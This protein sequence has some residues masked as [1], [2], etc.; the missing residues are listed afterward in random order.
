MAAQ[1]LEQTQQNKGGRPS[2][3]A[4]V[5]IQRTLRP[6][7]GRGMTAAYTARMTGINIKTVCK[8]FDEWANE[9]IERDEKYYHNRGSKERERVAMTYDILIS[10]EFA[11]LEK[12]TDEIERLEKQ[13]KEH[14]QHLK[15]EEQEILKT[16][17]FLIEKRAAYALHIL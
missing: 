9:I 10:R 12:I 5:Q 4:Q 13:K 11:S 15:K 8:Y 1:E 16:L 6:Y 7:F 3:I 2:K 17:S 14:P